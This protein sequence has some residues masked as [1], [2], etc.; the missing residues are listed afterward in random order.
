MLPWN[1]VNVYSYGGQPAPAER[2]IA[3]AVYWLLRHPKHRHTS[4]EGLG[5]KIRSRKVDVHRVPISNFRAG[6]R[7][8]SAILIHNAGDFAFDDFHFFFS[9]Q[10]KQVSD[11]A[12]VV[13]D[14]EQPVVGVLDDPGI[15]N[16]QQRNLLTFRL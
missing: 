9:A 10:A 13:L 14:V 8:N 4:V 15:K 12:D 6:R 11:A 1:Y 16:A 5:N 2:R 3:N 7:P